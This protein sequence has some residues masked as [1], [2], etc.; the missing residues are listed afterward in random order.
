MHPLREVRW[1][2]LAVLAVLVAA[3]LLGCPGEL[4]RKD[5]KVAQESAVTVGDTLRWPD[6]PPAKQD[7]WPTP[8]DSYTPAPFGCV[9]DNDCFGQRCGPTA[10]GVRLC[11]PSCGR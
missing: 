3:S 2:I 9:T 1:M 10:W 6:A 8:S 4:P 5:G 7:T 11:A